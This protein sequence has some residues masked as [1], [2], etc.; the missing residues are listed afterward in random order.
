MIKRIIKHDR[1]IVNN[2]FGKVGY[3]IFG[4]L[5]EERMKIALWDKTYEVMVFA[6]AKDKNTQINETQEKAY[7]HF[8][9]IICERK[10][11]LEKLLEDY[12]HTKDIEVLASKF[13]PTELT[14]GR[15]GECALSG[16]NTDD[17]EDYD[18]VPGLAIWIFPELRLDTDEDYRGI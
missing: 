5:A 17:G 16:K 15:N 8:K 6:S 10:N 14:F 3:F 7:V 18:D 9:E 12:Y 2:A 4:W 1:T 11:Q 13:I